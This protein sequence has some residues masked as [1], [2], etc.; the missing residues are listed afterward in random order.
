MRGIGGGCGGIMPE[1]NIGVAIIVSMYNPRTR[2]LVL[3]GI[4]LN[5]LN[6]NGNTNQQMVEK[7]VQ[8]MCKLWPN[9]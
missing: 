1:Q 9:E 2:E 3:G 6:D 4:A 8:E 5:R 7:S